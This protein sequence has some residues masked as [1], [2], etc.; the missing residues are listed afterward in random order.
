MEKDEFDFEVEYEKLKE[1]YD[2]P[3]LEK[4]CED[5]DVEKILDKETIFLIR[6]IRRTMNDKISAYIHLFEMLINPSGPPMFVFRILKNMSAEEKE[7]IQNFY[8]TLSKTQ[9]KV[10]KLDTVYSEKDEANFIIETFSVWQDMKKKIH[11]LFS[12][13]EENFEKDDT[14][15]GRSY[16]D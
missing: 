3:E 15:K 2:L 6:E 4:L 1:N 11:K 16:F 9:L 13:F 10:M 7:E 14:S 8:K 12:S 5:F